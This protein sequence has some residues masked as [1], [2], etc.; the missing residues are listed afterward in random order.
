MMMAPPVGYNREELI[1]GTMGQ[2]TMAPEVLIPRPP[3]TMSNQP[4]QFSRSAWDGS[5]STTSIGDG[6]STSVE[7]TTPITDDYDI[8]VENKDGQVKEEEELEVLADQEFDSILDN[9]MEEV[10]IVKGKKPI[11]TGL[12]HISRPP[13]AWILYRSDKLRSIAAG[14]RIPSDVRAQAV[15]ESGGDTDVSTEP[16]ANE[17]ESSAA[18]RTIED[19]G[20][21]KRKKKK[22]AAATVAFHAALEADAAKVSREG[23]KGMP[24]ADISKLISLMWKS[25]SKT[26]KAQYEKLATTKKAEVSETPNVASEGTFFFYSFLIGSQQH[27]ARYPDYKYQPMKKEDKERLKLEKEQEREAVRK[28]KAEQAKTSKLAT[29]TSQNSQLDRSTWMPNPS[30]RTSEIAGQ[31]QTLRRSQPS[32]IPLVASPE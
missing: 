11:L 30:A 21:K 27:Q 20:T 14:E 10:P 2:G 17:G 7:G 19:G 23:G 32:S 25:E 3:F 18:P 15:E 22:P 28:E 6:T 8:N 26:V 16:G 13:N 31:S 12:S 29:L 9:N 24:Q 5:G 1:Q 4:V